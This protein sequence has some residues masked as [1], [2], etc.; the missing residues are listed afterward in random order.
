M[1]LEFLPEEP[2]QPRQAVLTIRGDKTTLLKAKPVP[3]LTAA[4]LYEYAGDYASAELLGAVYTLFIEG[5]KLL[6]KFRAFPDM[7]LQP[8][9]PDAY[10]A[11]SANVDFLRDKAQRITGFTLSSGRMI[12]I[13]FVK[14]RS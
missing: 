3:E 14:R 7:R 9:A 2:G 13:E 8:M 6:L 12:G 5:D 4:Q 11:N 1:S 10:N